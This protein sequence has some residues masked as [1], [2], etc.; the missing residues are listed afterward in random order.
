M[1][2][3][4]GQFMDKTCKTLDR[5]C[6]QKWEEAKHPEKLQLENE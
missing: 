3:G 1:V 6:R 4:E 5:Y 2:V